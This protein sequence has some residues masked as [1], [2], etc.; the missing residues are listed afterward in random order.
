MCPGDLLEE[1]KEA[2]TALNAWSDVADMSNKIQFV[3]T[4][5]YSG[6]LY[7]T[8]TLQPSRSNRL[9]LSLINTTGY[10]VTSEY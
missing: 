2:A 8:L 5:L 1:E 4:D 3:Q 7:T 6:I 10:L 9:L